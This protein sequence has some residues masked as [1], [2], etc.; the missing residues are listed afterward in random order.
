MPRDRYYGGRPMQYPLLIIIADLSS[1]ILLMKRAILLLG[2]LHLEFVLSVYLLIEV[3]E[4]LD[5]GG[6]KCGV[7]YVAWCH[8]GLFCCIAFDTFCSVSL[9]ALPSQDLTSGVELVFAGLSRRVY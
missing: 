6:W 1:V 2:L 4:R 7:V 9:Y 5:H 8:S 3:W